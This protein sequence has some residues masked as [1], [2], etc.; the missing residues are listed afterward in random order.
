MNSTDPAPRRS[1]SDPATAATRIVREAL[2]D[3]AERMQVANVEAVLRQLQNGDP[4][5]WGEYQSAVAQHV[6]AYLETCD[7]N[8]KATYIY[9]NEWSPDQL[10]ADDNALAPM[11]HLIIWAQPKTAALR[12]LIDILNRALALRLGQVVG[13]LSVA[14]LLDVQVIDDSEMSRR[15]GYAA[16]LTSS[17]MRPAQVHKRQ[18]ASA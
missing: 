6:G 4:S 16:L 11:I 1:W 7:E 13:K 9:D 2:R 8:V 3:S 18:A 15:S 10:S 17:H 14:Q 5:S 12:A